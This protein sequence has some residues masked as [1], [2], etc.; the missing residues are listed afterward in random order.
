MA[1][2]PTMMTLF[3]DPVVEEALKR[4]KRA[5]EWTANFRQRFVN[6]IK[7]RHGDANNGY[8]WP[9]MIKRS[10]DVDQKP[11]LTINMIRQH[12]LQIVN[13][14]KQNK[15]SVKIVSMGGGSSQESAGIFKSLVKHTEY[16]SNAQ[17]AY[18]TALEFAVDGGLGWWRLVT[19]YVDNNSDDQEAYIRRVPDP[20]AVFSDP[21]AVEKDKSDMNWL[22]YF[23]LIPTADF[24]EMYP[25]LKGLI[26]DAP[27]GIGSMANDS[28][29]IP[30]HIRVCEY[31][32]KVQKDDTLVR[33]IDP[34]TGERKSILKSQLPKNL[35]KIV[36]DDPMTVTRLVKETT[37][38]W[39]LI[40]G[41]RVV[42]ETEWMGSY[43]P[44]IP[45]IGE[46]TLIDGQYDCKGHTRN[47]MDAQRMYNYN[48]SAQTEFVALQSKTPW[49][50]SAKAIEE[51]ESM[52]NTANLDNHS[53]LIWNDV[54]DDNPDREI[55]PPF[56]QEPPSAAPAY[57]AGMETAFNQM[58]MA[59]G[60]WQNQMGMGGNERTGK[61][62]SERQQQ[63]DTSVFHFQDNYEMSLRLQ[64]KMLIDLYP[65]IF[66]T[67]RIL[68]L[69]ADDGTEFDLLIDPAARQAFQ[70]MS[71]HRGEVVQRVLNPRVGKYEV[72][73]E[74]GPAYGTKR[75]E[76]VDAM[77][78]ILSQN[79][80]LTG[81]IGDLL[82]DSMDFD[83]AQEAARRM[84]RMVPP[85][86]L[87]QGPSQQEQQLQQQNQALTA[88]LGKSLEAHGK[89]KLRLTGK[90]EM[91][92]IDTYKAQTDRFEAFKD[93][94]GLDV[95]SVKKMV[96]QL[97]QDSISNRL[98]PI[99]K[100][101]QGDVGVQTGSGLAA[102]SG[103]A[104][105]NDAGGPPLPGAKKAPD[106]EWYILD[107]TRRGK[108]LRIAPLAQK[109]QPPGEA[110]A[111]Q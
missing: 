46:E 100:A 109:R 80:G 103:S 65:R 39:K 41:E 95:E 31:F 98:S 62:I 8:Q 28:W 6:D 69:L 57:Q 82:L 45:V 104:A 110:S 42:D 101:N 58:M 102:Q 7:F 85:I 23:D 55:K 16:I 24:D 86:A 81:I 33:F 25:R 34:M 78:L 4:Y 30:D 37:V 38:E 71:N 75:A 87:G 67:R 3:G 93:M 44:F 11:C 76:S 60:Q 22:L 17:S 19:D 94:A 54:D 43:I 74:V 26:G 66:D 10:R 73:A 12:N 52:W 21:D 64:G 90:A 106:G 32:R 108:Y 20:L 5:S 63:S 111:G 72:G 40:A 105:V 9:N 29:S 15:S 92:D 53:V 91:R 97:V 99:V 49:I 77:N 1:A 18:S 27:L 70:I 47:L 61:A 68:A 2:D 50:A 36:L 79:P 48:A 88:A 89:D 84:K 107:P 13:Q 14:A 51:Y 96:E 35:V 56:R 83:K 59:S